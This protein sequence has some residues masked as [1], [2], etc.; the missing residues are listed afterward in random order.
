MF[1]PIA[2]ACRRAA[3]RF[4]LL[5]AIVPA[6]LLV[7]AGPAV[8]A[9]STRVRV[10]YQPGAT[11]L[12]LLVMKHH[13]L[14]EKHAQR[15]GM[16][17]VETTWTVFGSGAAMNDALLSGQ[18]DFAATGTPPAITL[19]ARTRDNLGA[20]AVAAFADVPQYL[21]TTNPNVRSLRDFTDKDRIAVPAVKVSIQAVTLQMAAAKEFGAASFGKL[22][23]LTVSMPHPEAFA[24]IMS[25]RSEITAHF[26]NIPFMNKQLEDKRVRRVLSSYD[27][28]GGPASNGVVVALTAFH[29]DNPRA[30]RAFLAGLEEAMD[31]IKADLRA[32]VRIYI[33]ESKDKESEDFLV[34]MLSSPDIAFTVE[35]H[36]TMVYATFMH[37]R[38]LIKVRPASW[39]DMF[40]PEIHGR[41][42]S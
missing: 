33:A 9:E 19:W 21:V 32:A 41:N 11:Y 1:G 10:A 14:V 22:D 27:V 39:K 25:G 18:V 8:A 17:P 16:P 6:L 2:R 13:K 23:H 36:N 40:F 35:P 3:H 29:R 20:K 31:I 15:L 30:Y 4:V 26:S 24:A 34:K 38:G 12:P 28:L 7:A 42:G 37:E 5:G